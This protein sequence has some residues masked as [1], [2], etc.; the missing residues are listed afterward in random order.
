MSL[1]SVLMVFLIF[2]FALSSG[3]SR[4]WSGLAMIGFW[5]E[6]DGRILVGL[7]LFLESVTPSWTRLMH[8]YH[9][10]KNGFGNF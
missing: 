5:R 4:Q 8:G 9:S 10:F 1:T 2:W 6:R 3:V 7:F